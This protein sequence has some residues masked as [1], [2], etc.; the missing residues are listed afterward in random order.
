MKYETYEAPIPQEVIEKVAQA[1]EKILGGLSREKYT[2]TLTNMPDVFFILAKKDDEVTGFKIGFSIKKDR[3]YSWLG[4]VDEAYRGN[5]IAK[6]LMLLQHKWCQ[7]KGFKTIETKTLNKWKEM[8]IL[9]LR[10]GF[11][12]KG[13]QE[14]KE[15]GVQIM[16]E[17]RV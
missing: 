6:E 2:W 15:H 1:C 14:S 17:K 8:L 4:G 10:S 5:G 16:L 13:L 7:E 3:F 12:I 9:N 11:E